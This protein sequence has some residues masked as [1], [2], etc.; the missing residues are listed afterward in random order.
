[1]FSLDRWQEIFQT[2]SKNKLRAFLTGLSVSSGI[3]ILVILLGVSRGM[4]NGIEKEFQQDAVTEVE[5][6][7]GTTTVG[8]KGM[9][10]GRRVQLENE[11]YE[12]TTQKFGDQIDSKSGYFGRWGAIINYK[13]ENG[14]YEFAGVHPDFQKVENA[15]IISGRFINASDIEGNDKVAVIGNRVKLD[16]FKDKDPIGEYINISKVPFKV[17]GVY[18]D[19]GGEREET[20]VYLPLTTAQR[21]FNGK[22]Q[23][24]M[25]SFTIKPAATFD[26]AVQNAAFLS[27]GLEKSLKQRHLVSPDD[28][29][30]IRVFDT[31]E[32]AK[33]I[34]DLLSYID[35][36]FWIVG[37]CTIIAGVVGVGNIMLIVVKERTKEI[38][39]RKAIGAQPMSI[40]GM[41]LQEAVFVTFVAGFFGLFAG[42]L[43]LEVV[44]PQI[45]SDFFANPEVDMNVALSTIVILIIA[46]ALAGFF[47]A[48]RAAKIKPIIAL[49]DE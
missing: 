7:T 13:K 1:M 49:R 6:W 10:P 26:E 46:G 8:Y 3:F 9:N 30:G 21:V 20:R 43:L 28:T 37:I 4:Q 35:L 32:E 11:D 31:L 16:L 24:R 19:P 36:F 23:L 25:L 41:I 48:Y 34:Y 27:D 17:V 40:I 18:T 33:R 5:V 14:S 29:S 44:G 22:N 15:T 12:Y 38:G 47:P 2:L 45:Q 39:I 42:L